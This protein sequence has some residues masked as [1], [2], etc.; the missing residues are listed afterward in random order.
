M[1]DSRCAFRCS[2]LRRAAL[3]A[4]DAG[5]SVR[6]FP[7]AGLP[8]AERSARAAGCAAASGARL[9]FFGAVEM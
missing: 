2:A 1:R 8:D 6:T 9:S 4:E 5:L 7:A 3:G